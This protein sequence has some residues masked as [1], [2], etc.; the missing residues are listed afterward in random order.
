MWAKGSL[1]TSL[2]VWQVLGSK[3]RSCQTE[4]NRKW[5]YWVSAMGRRS[6]LNISNISLSFSVFFFGVHIAGKHLDRLHPLSA[7]F[8]W[9]SYLKLCHLSSAQQISTH[10]LHRFDWLIWF[11]FIYFLSALYFVVAVHQATYSCLIKTFLSYITFFF[12]FLGS[13]RVTCNL[14]PIT[15]QQ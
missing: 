4:T 11:I 5:L 14:Y 12:F 7:T 2:L 8:D 15:F 3:N 1:Y 9:F 10:R 6:H 13:F